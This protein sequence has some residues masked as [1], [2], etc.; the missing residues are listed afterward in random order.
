MDFNRSE[1]E[2]QMR[3][4][5]N[6]E[7]SKDLKASNRPVNSLVDADLDFQTNIVNIP[8][9]KEENSSILKYITQRYR[10]K[11]FDN[12]EF[13]QEVEK[14]EEEVY[15][16]TPIESSKEIFEIYDKIEAAIKKMTQF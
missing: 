16:E 2:E 11:T 1:I 5:E 12:Y 10:E 14:I 13:K 9:T 7:N 4:G 15:D 8:I 3:I 6:W